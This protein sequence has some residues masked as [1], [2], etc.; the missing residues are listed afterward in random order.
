[1]MF[2]TS[3]ARVVHGAAVLAPPEDALIQVISREFA[4]ELVKPMRCRARG[5]LHG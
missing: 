5:Y 2:K 3:S 1:M 4:E